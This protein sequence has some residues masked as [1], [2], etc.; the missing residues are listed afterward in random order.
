MNT[1]QLLRAL[2]EKG[3]A[4]AATLPLALALPL[5]TVALVIY[6]P[7]ALAQNV[8]EDV[9]V[10]KGAAGRTT[11]TFTLKDAL[12]A[13]PSLFAIATPPRLVLDFANTTSLSKATNEV[14]DS[15]L[16]SYNV[17]QAQ[18]RTRV[19]LNL[20]KSQAYDVKVDGK[21]LSLALYDAPGTAATE[22][23]PTTGRFTGSAASDGA[24]F[25]LRDVDFRRGQAGEGRIIV[26]LTDANSG[27]DIKPQGKVLIVDFLRTTVPRNLERKL[28]VADFG[29]PVQVID[30]FSGWQHPYGDRA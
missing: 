7:E 11:L 28:D 26:D 22:A 29:T 18:G 25:G 21:K 16:R 17:V 27:I 12:P 4:L 23:A 15:V 30:T 19:V 5:T 6:T 8:I 14:T 1:R 3:R 13:A 9:A 20:L 24:T 2:R 10:A